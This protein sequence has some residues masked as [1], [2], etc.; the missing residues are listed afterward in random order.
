MLRT[1]DLDVHVHVCGVGSDWERRHLLF[2]D[3]L[4]Q[5]D[6]DRVPYA[7][8]KTTLAQRSWPTTDHYAAAKTT[9]ISEI[10]QRSEAW[11]A[12]GAWSMITTS[13]ALA[14]YPRLAGGGVG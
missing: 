7:S 6:G 11:A 3:W 2:R 12:S 5:S 1:P 4:R 8:T 13:A 14:R 10:M 9:V